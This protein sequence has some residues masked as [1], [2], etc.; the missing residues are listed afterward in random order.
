MERGDESKPKNAA[1]IPFSALVIVLN[2][3]L[4]AA[5]DSHHHF[6]RGK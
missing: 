2:G 4:V 3:S 6:I 5:F 1:G